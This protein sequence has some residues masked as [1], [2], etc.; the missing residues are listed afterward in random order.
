MITDKRGLAARIVGSGEDVA[1]RAVDRT[2]AG[3]VRAR[4]RGGGRMNRR[5]AG[6][7]GGS[8]PDVARPPARRGRAEGPQ[9]PRRRSDRRGGPSAS[10]RCSNPSRSARRLTRG[11]AYARKG[12]VISLDVEPGRRARRC[13]GLPGAAV[14]GD[15][16][17]R[18]AARADLGQG[19][20]RLVGAGSAQRE[21]A[22]RGGA[23]GAR[24]DL[25]RRRRGAVPHQRSATWL[26][27]A[28]ARIGRCPASTWRDL[29][30]A[31][32]GVRRRPVPHP[33]LARPRPGGVA[34][35]VA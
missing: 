20:D 31:G 17:L 6:G 35:S 25:R 16:R 14:S 3:A 10:W 28:A 27:A 33:A 8:Y 15:D 5:W 4:G 30:S 9:R 18:A 13:P 22:R 21:T 29:L 34:G 24:G 26:S 19:R 23:A 11:R 1:D 32:R 7:F 2:A 12:Q